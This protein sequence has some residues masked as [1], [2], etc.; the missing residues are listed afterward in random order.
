MNPVYVTY[1]SLAIA[2]A[3][4]VA[5]TSLLQQTQQFTRLWPS[6]M[7]LLC[8][9]AAFYMLSIAL[10]TLPVGIAY[11]LWSGFGIVLVSAV[12]WFVFRQGLDLAAIIGLALIIAGIVVINVFSSTV[13]H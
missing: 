6:V 7:S 2:V 1:G 9:G 13:S 11:A 12:G 4:E 5:G 10:R 3:F 8:Y